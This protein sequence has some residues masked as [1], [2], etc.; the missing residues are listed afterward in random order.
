MDALRATVT[1][2]PDAVAR[3][4]EQRPATQEQRPASDSPAPEALAIHPAPVD[5]LF[6]DGQCPLCAGE[7]A[8]LRKTRGDALRVVDIHEL[9]N[10]SRVERPG[11]S[12]GKLDQ[13][14][15]QPDKDQ[16][17]RVLHLQ[18]ADGSWLTSADANVAA[19]EGT[20]HGRTLRML[21]WPVVRHVV[22]L[23]YALWARWRYQRLYGKQFDETVHAPDER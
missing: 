4:Q 8:Q 18:R 23:V 20:A 22:D 12:P 17:L 2:E 10:G 16:L 11:I 21:R 5:T 6:F 3:I 13:A 15:L 9:P 14:E 7:I 19:W 1:L